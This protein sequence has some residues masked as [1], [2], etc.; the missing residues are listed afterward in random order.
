MSSHATAV[1]IGDGKDWQFIG[2]D[3]SDGPDGLMTIDPAILNVDGDYM[4]GMH[5]AINRKL[6]YQ[7]CTIK[8]D[9]SLTGLTDTGVVLRARDESHCYLVHFPNCPQGSRAQ[10]FWVVLSVMDESGYLRHVKMQMVPRVSSMNNTPLSAEVS[11]RGKRISV[12]VG[13][14]G[15]FEAEDTTYAG[16]GQ[17]GLYLFGAAKLKNVSIEGTAVTHTSVWRPEVRQPV[18]WRHPL[19]SDKKLWQQPLDIKRFDDGEL[20]MLVNIQDNTSSAEDTG[21]APFLTRSTDGGST[22]SEPAPLEI[23]EVKNQWSSA[24]M[25]ITPTGRL[26]GF[27]PGSDHKMVSEST[28][29]G[30]TWKPIGKTNLHIGPPREKPVQDISPQGLMNLKY[31]SMLVFHLNGGP[32]LEDD[33][34]GLLTWGAKHCQGFSRRSD[35]DGAT[36][37]ELV[38]LD[39]P[40]YDPDGNKLEGNLDFTEVSAVELASGRIMGFSR[41]RPVSR[42][43][44]PEH[45]PHRMR[46][47]D[48]RRASTWFN[49]VLQPRRRA[50]LGPGHDH[51]YRRMGDGLDGR[52]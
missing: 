51:R 16:P 26:I 2:G 5:Y 10:H 42:L 28:D 22:W 12:C 13:E 20:L 7:D 11:I 15:R 31:G 35:D 32:N 36:W 44:R 34:Y 19:P 6:C 48:H 43:C 23:G 52:S 40:G 29:R 27:V 21:A 39:S 50:D 1:T 47:I 4:Q 38:N 24:R 3:W 18:N 37:G 46:R 49:R 25:H 17:A 14:Y 33:R 9:F 45:G 41:A 30:R 8:F